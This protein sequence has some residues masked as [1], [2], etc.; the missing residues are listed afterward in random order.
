MDNPVDA[1][2]TRRGADRLAAWLGPCR[3]LLFRRLAA[4]ITGGAL[5]LALLLLFWRSVQ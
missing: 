5:A 1:K 2:G 4:V 3:A